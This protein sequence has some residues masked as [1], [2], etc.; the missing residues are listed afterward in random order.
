V[1][2]IFFLNISKFFVL[3]SAPVNWNNQR[4]HNLL[5]LG[6]RVF[7]DI[8]L[9]SLS[10]SPR[11]IKDKSK[12]DDDV[13]KE[14]WR[15]KKTLAKGNGRMRQ[16]CSLSLSIAQKLFA[17]T[18]R[19]Q[20]PITSR[21]S[22]DCTCQWWRPCSAAAILVI[23]QAISNI[24]LIYNSPLLSFVIIFRRKRTFRLLHGQIRCADLWI[25]RNYNMKHGRESCRLLL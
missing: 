13:M 11:K 14:S 18:F 19:R 9:S 22:R 1:P 4:R 3:F 24:F 15:D 17:A 16:P 12:S 5:L 10:F 8:C 7:I 25:D 6:V 21:S 20:L 23:I 2:S